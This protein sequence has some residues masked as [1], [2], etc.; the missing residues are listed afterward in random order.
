M[1]D[2]ISLAYVPLL[3]NLPGAFIVTLNFGLI[4]QKGN[5]VLLQKLGLLE[6]IS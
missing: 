6:N 4:K 3:L 2:L 5:L 1:N